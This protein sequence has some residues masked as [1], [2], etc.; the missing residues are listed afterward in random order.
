MIIKKRIWGK[1]DFY[2]PKHTFRQNKMFSFLKRKV[3]NGLILDA[4]C[5]KGEQTLRLLKEGYNVVAVEV[6][7]ENLNHIKSNLNRSNLNHRVKLLKSPLETFELERNILDGIVCGEVLEHVEDDDKVLR[8]F[9][10]FLKEGGHCIITAPLN[11]KYWNIDDEWAG[12]NRRYSLESLTHVVEKNGFKIEKI[13]YYGPFM[14]WY[15]NNIYLP[16]LRK[17]LKN[18][19]PEVELKKK[20]HFPSFLKGLTRHLHFLFYLDEIFKYPA[21]KSIYFLADIKKIKEVSKDG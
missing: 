11:K 5:G 20:T 21:E 8:N 7:D 17:K 16:I 2:G 15:F 13:N 18:Y 9:N 4:G 10:L 1:D 19:N 3:K 14:K 12:H 6:N